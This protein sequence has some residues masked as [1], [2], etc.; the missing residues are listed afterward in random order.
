MPGG[1]GVRWDGG[2]DVGDEVT[3]HYD[4]LLAKLIV[5]APDRRQAITR[6]RRALD[7]LAVL[8][9]ATNQ[10]FHRRLMADPAFREGEIDIQ[11]LDRRPD[12][13]QPAPGPDDVRRLAVAAALAEDQA[14]DSR[15]ARRRGRRAAR[16]VRRGVAAQ[17]AARRAAVTAARIL[18]LAA[19]GDG[20]G[21]LEDGRTVF[22]PRTA[23]GDL[24]ELGA[25]RA[26]KR[27]ARARIGRLLEASAGADRAALSPLRAR[28]L[29]RLPVAAPPA[30]GAARG[31]SRVRG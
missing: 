26:H 22:V 29:R 19:G 11:F 21:K 24:V 10:G 17:R 31:T 23:P 3:L 30:R 18:R 28:R 12:L 7:E 20:V 2:V 4:S 27:F 8:G 15:R 6:M 16:P 14:R 13:L 1:P 25:V 9:V 5:H